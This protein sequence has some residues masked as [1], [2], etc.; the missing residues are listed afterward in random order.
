MPRPGGGEPPQSELE[1]MEPQGMML[2]ESRKRA[3]LLADVAELTAGVTRKR[4]DEEQRTE[5][6]QELQEVAGCRRLQPERALKRAT[7]A[8]NN[9]GALGLA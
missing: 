7:A 5:G 8:G 1:A 3:L 6:R 4:S 9:L 2:L